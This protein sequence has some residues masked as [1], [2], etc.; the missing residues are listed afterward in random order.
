MAAVVG[1]ANEAKAEPH[2]HFRTSAR[3]AGEYV[4]L[5]DVMEL[6][7]RD[8]LMGAGLDA[9]A[10]ARIDSP[11]TAQDVPVEA[12]ARRIVA[13]IPGLAG[14]LEYAPGQTIRISLRDRSVGTSPAPVVAGPLRECDS[15]TTSVAR[16]KA[17]RETDLRPEP[18]PLDKA[19]TNGIRYDTASHVARASRDLVAGMIVERVPQRAL[20]SML[21]GDELKVHVHFGVVDV[22]RQVRALQDTPLGRG[23]FVETAEGGI[24]SVRP[25]GAARPSLD[26][27][28][29]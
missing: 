8:P 9:I 25:M 28:H 26:E 2:L 19:P 20:A 4:H 5:S 1:M 21:R 22:A 14:R 17:L 23:L 15:V 10:V 13:Q 11:S 16:G 7:S 12:L 24:L 18:C 29:P 6:D 27:L 3:L